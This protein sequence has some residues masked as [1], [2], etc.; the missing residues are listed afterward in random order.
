[1]VVVVGAG[2]AGIAV[3]EKLMEKG[4][5]VTVYDMRGKVVSWQTLPG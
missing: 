1:M 4:I 2:Y 5:E 3:A